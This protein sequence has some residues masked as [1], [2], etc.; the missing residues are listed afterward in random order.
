MLEAISTSQ[1]YMQEGVSGN[2][3][4]ELR[5]R[6]TFDGFSEER[7]QSLLKEMWNKVEY[8]LKDPQKSAGQL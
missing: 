5:K 3:V 4:A 8:A 7:M 2:I 6:R 1:D